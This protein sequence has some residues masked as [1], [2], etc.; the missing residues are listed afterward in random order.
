MIVAGGEHPGGRRALFLGISEENV[1]EIRAN[2]MLEMDIPN[3]GL[4]LI[5]FGGRGDDATLRAKLEEFYDLSPEPE[6]L[7]EHRIAC[8]NCGEEAIG[9]TDPGTDYIHM[10]ECGGCGYKEDWS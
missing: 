4:T 8:A 10:V 9:Y 5:L 7:E 1:E 2:Q 3:F 6:A